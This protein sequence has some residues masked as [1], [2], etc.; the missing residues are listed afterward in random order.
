[1]ALRLKHVGNIEL[2]ALPAIITQVHHQSCRTAV[3]DILSL[4]GGSSQGDC[5]RQSGWRRQEGRCIY[6]S[7][8][9]GRNVFNR[10]GSC[11]LRVRS[12]RHSRRWQSG[13]HF[14]DRIDRTA[15]ISSRKIQPPSQTLIDIGYSI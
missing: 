11:G 14:S 7:F 8:L 6:R 4:P 5:A 10:F 3:V 2:S 12:N 1:M 13:G 9:D 15:Q